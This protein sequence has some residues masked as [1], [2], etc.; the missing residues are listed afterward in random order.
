LVIAPK[1]RTAVLL[2]ATLL[3]LWTLVQLLSSPVAR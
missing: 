2:I 1:F 3:C